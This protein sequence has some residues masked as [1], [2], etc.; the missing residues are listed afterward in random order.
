[1]HRA[2]ILGPLA[3]AV[4]AACLAATP[5]AAR[6]TAAAAQAGCYARHY[7][8]AH[9]AA[10]PAQR[11]EAIWLGRTPASQARPVGHRTDSVLAF[12]FRLS[13]RTY[14]GMAYCRGERCE[15]E[16]D[17]G[18]FTLARQGRDM[19]LA[20]GSRL[21]LEGVHDFSPD[22]ARSADDRVFLL[23]PASPRACR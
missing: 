14:S 13:G 10:H 6:D 15:I 7:E 8:A 17:A 20:V 23:H 12:G 1:M 11:V 3:G 19:R 2:S 21:S 18:S 16:G 5:A 4:L 9:L 22:L